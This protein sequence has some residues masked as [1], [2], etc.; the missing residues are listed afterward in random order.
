MNRV[1]RPYYGEALRLLGDGAA[2]IETIDRA[3]QDAGFPM[4]PFRLMDLIG[5][6]INFAAARSV[7]EGFFEEPRFRPHPI[8][9]QMVESGRLGR[10]TGRGYYDYR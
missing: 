3:L 5:I 6:D 1:A 2:D 7:F 10:K 4:G 9:R 8:Q